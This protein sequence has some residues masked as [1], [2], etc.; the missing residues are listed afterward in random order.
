ML[1]GASEET[2]EKAPTVTDQG[3]VVGF[4]LSPAIGLHSVVNRL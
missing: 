3:C 1:T 4:G 2:N